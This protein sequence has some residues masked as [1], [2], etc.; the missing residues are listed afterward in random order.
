MN[1]MNEPFQALAAGRSIGAILIDS[2]RLTPEAAER[3]LK[4]QKEENLRFGDAAVRL[5]VLSEADIQQALSHQFEYSYLAPGDERVSEE[6]VAA[7]KPFTPIVEQLRVLRSQLLLR[8]FDAEVGHNALAI[9][10]PGA[11]EGRSFIAANLAVVFSQ[12][13]ERTLLIDAD[14]RHPRQHELFRLPNKTGL[15]SVLAGRERLGN[16]VARVPGLQNLTILPA[17]PV[18]PNPQEL[19]NRPMFGQLVS[20]MQ[21]KLDVVIVDTPAGMETADCQAIASHIRG[22]VAIARKDVTASLD[23]QELVTNLQ[24]GGTTVVGSL[25]NKG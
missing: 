9:V 8:W 22:A 23:F 17:G 25:L 5:G 1:A 19:L 6:V 3:V 2:G 11:G 14:M 7:F 18:P 10:S 15:S 13:G 4:L 21:R 20:A 24:Q 16:V 12:L